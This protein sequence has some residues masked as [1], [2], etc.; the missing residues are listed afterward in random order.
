MVGQLYW[1][2]CP[3]SLMSYGATEPVRYGEMCQLRSHCSMLQCGMGDRLVQERAVHLEG[4]SVQNVDEPFSEQ[5]G[6][7]FPWAHSPLTVCWYAGMDYT[8]VICCISPGCEEV[9]SRACAS[10]SMMPQS[11]YYFHIDNTNPTAIN[12][13]CIVAVARWWV[14]SRPYHRRYAL[15]TMMPSR[16]CLCPVLYS[17]SCSSRSVQDALLFPTLGIVL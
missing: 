6:T 14:Y 8:S 12:E 15:L 11:Y 16:F 4:A 2:M 10:G 13:T 7:I 5:V 9:R 17:A 3:W 1:S